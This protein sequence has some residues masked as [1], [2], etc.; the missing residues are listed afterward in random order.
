MN[1][2]DVTSFNQ[3]EHSRVRLKSVYGK[4]SRAVDSNVLNTIRP[5]PK[6]K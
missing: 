3:P 1:R 6:L 2:F 4:G 5:T